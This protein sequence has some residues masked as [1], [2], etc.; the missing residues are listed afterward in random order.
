MQT[1][2][3]AIRLVVNSQSAMPD[4]TTLNPAAK[5]TAIAI[6]HLD[7]LLIF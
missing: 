5:A 6:N 2:N 1:M 7:A 4:G 3:A